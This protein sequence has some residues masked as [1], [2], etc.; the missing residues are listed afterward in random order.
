MDSFA[1]AVSRIIK[2]QQ[3]IIGPIAVDQAKKVAGLQV[4]NAD[5]VKVTGNHKEVLTNLV[6]QYSQ[7][8][9]KASVEVCKEA[10]EPFE[11][12]IPAS[13]VPDILKN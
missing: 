12:K 2:E 6:N 7:L 3:D 13:E 5:D 9:G 10:F 1:Q 11:D 4:S 8:F